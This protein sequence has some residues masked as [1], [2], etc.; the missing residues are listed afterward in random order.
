MYGVTR[1]AIRKAIREQKT[2][3][4]TNKKEKHLRRKIFKSLF[5]C[6]SIYICPWGKKTLSN[7]FD[8]TI[9]SYDSAESWLLEK[10]LMRFSCPMG[11]YDGAESCELVG[12]YLPHKIKEEF[13]S[14]CDFG[15][16]HDDGLGIS[17]ASPRQT[18]VIK[19]DLCG[20]FRNYGLKITIE[21]NKKAVDFLNV[22][23]NLSGGMHMAYT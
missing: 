15:L 11:S 3:W 20:I 16:Y 6:V 2:T 9:G 10:D 19:K 23:L 14:I 5:V 17:R 21:T 12:A 4:E 22:T 7:L 18:E 13:G 8:I 1:E